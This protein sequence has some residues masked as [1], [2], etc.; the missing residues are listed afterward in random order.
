MCQP[1]KKNDLLSQIFILS[2][3]KEKI[4]ELKKENEDLK[5]LCNSYKL[6]LKIY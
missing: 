5:I 6:L 2:E 4:K 1:P 3:L